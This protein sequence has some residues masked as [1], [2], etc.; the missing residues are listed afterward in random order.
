MC[1]KNESSKPNI[2]RSLIGQWS[3]S[4]RLTLLYA[5]SSFLMLVLATAYLYW[6]LVGNLAREDNAFLADKIAVFRNLL[7]EHPE[8]MGS[9]KNEMALAG[10]TPPPLEYYVRILKTNSETVV[11]TLGMSN[12][13]PGT[14]F[15][16]PVGADELPQ[17]I[18]EVTLPNGKSFRLMCAQANVGARGEE[19]HLIQIA[20]DVTN[21][22]ALIKSFRRK[23]LA[24]MT[25]GLLF[26]CI[27]GVLIARKGLQPLDELTQATERI[28]VSHLHERIAR[29]GWPRELGSLAKGFNR[30]LERLEDS[31]NRLSQFCGDLAHEL[32]TPINNLRGEA[33]V[34][35]SQ[36][37]TPEQYR[38]V[39]ESSLEEY[40]RVSRLI[41]NL[42]FLARA[43]SPTTSI[44]RSRFDARQAIET[45]RSYYEAL[46]DERGV[47]VVCEGDATMEADPV[48][49]RQ[50]ISNL[51]SNAL[52]FTPPGGNVI[53]TVRG[54]DSA[55]EVTVRDS[56]CGIPTEHLPRIFDR[57]YRVDRARSQN[58]SGAGLGLAIVKSIVTLHGGLVEVESEPG[59]GTRF[60][61]TFPAGLPETR[62]KN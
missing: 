21:D 12:L 13:V 16:E 22:N 3:I 4:R 31:F 30:M 51:L 39:L 24:L 9:F 38:R 44:Q 26:A 37:R 36:A 53:T 5:A 61:L 18:G 47:A 20:L 35:L 8:V 23:V 25:A 56:G 58:S 11:E 6:S 10:Q 15:P 17:K 42:L 1:S 46:A 48:L 55:V 59:N 41:E 43:D 45:V 19:Q 33:G 50:A 49:F 54:R 14:M 40:A 60:R 34:A 7:R 28:S 2:V 52:N 32:R 62:K 27:A 29:E 57:L